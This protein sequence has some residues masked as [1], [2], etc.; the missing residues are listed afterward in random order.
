MWRDDI[1]RKLTHAW[2]RFGF[3]P[4]SIDLYDFSEEHVLRHA[5][6]PFTTDHANTGEQD[7]TRVGVDVPPC[8]PIDD[9]DESVEGDSSVGSQSWLGQ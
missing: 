2:L 7:A 6:P 5:L 3:S 9:G 1:S 8:E 4:T